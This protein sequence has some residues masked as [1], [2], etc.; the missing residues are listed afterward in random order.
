MPWLGD[1]DWF[2]ATG[3]LLLAAMV[4]FAGPARFSR[5]RPGW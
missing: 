5:N 2:R 1:A 3:G 4:C